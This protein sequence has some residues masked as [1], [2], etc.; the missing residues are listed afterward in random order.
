MCCEKQPENVEKK[1]NQILSMLSSPNE[2]E[3]IKQIIAKDDPFIINL[4]L[5]QDS[6][7][8]DISEGIS[9]S[10][11]QLYCYSKNITIL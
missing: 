6:D 9:K 1:K 11:R 2:S 3:I 10:K 8:P 4:V 7:I 5:S